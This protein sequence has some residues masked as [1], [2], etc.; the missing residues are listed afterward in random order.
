MSV[1]LKP[2]CQRNEMAMNPWTLDFI[3]MLLHGGSDHKTLSFD[4]GDTY[5]QAGVMTYFLTGTFIHFC[6][7]VCLF[8]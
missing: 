5:L 2:F 3:V 1:D 6:L 4:T 7:S 8:V